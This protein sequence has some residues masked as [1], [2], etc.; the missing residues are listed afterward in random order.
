VLRVGF[1]PI[2]L[3]E[4]CDCEWLGLWT[5][6]IPTAPKKKKKALANFSTIRE[7]DLSLHAL[8]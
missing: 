1:L 5:D 3:Q 6:F 7:E 2:D 8:E 4:T